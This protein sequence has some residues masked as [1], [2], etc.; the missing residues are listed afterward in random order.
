MKKGKL[1][2][3]ELSAV[4]EELEMNSDE[5]E[6]LYDA[7]ENHGIDLPLEEFIADLPPEEELLDDIPEDIG[8]V[9][10]VYLIGEGTDLSGLEKLKNLERLSLHYYTGDLSLAKDLTMETFVIENE[11]TQEAVDTFTYSET[12]YELHLNDETMTKASKCID[13]MIELG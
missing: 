13:K 11:T 10:E 6:K 8:E 1:S 9:E 2:Q 5:I 12:V 7:L 4:A 3:K